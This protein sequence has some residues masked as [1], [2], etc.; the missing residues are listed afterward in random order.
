MET[1]FPVELMCL[2]C[3]EPR[4]F[5]DVAG[6]PLRCVSC[7][8]PYRRITV[9]GEIVAPRPAARRRT[10]HPRPSIPEPRLS[11]FFPAELMC[12]TC[13]V[14]RRFRDAGKRP[15]RCEACDDPYRRVT[16][17]GEIVEPGASD[18][19]RY[20]GPIPEQRTGEHGGM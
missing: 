13:G 19:I 7:T 5:T 15:L 9:G 1:F 10:D 17:N 4:R 12:V 18:Y 6:E 8:D 20:L 14:P 2:T 16:V 3:D 11:A